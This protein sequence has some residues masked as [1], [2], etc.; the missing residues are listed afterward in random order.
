MKRV[1]CQQFN[2]RL[3]K[4]PRGCVLKKDCIYGCPQ[5]L[6]KGHHSPIRWKELG[7]LTPK[8]KAKIAKEDK[9]YH[10]ALKQI[11]IIKDHRAK[12]TDKSKGVS[13]LMCPNDE[14]GNTISEDIIRLRDGFYQCRRCGELFIQGN[15]VDSFD[16]DGLDEN[17]L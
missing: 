12:T 6:R 17:M 14:C 10:A 8:E 5:Y 16:F 9:A 1:S 7:E 13:V 11:P 3:A 2:T 4:G 15:V